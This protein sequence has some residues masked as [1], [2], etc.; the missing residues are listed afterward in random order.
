MSEQKTDIGKDKVFIYQIFYDQKSKEKLDPGF[1]PLDNSNNLR[2]DWY[3]FWPIR[4]FLNSHNLEPDAW[5]GFLSPRFSEKTGLNSVFLKN[6]LDN[7]AQNCEVLLFSYAWDQLSYFLNPFEQGEL[8][9]AGISE[10]TQ[11]FFDL[12]GVNININSFVTC[13]NTSVFSNYIIAKPSYWEKW[14]LLAEMF[15][16]V[17]EQGDIP[18]LTYNTSYVSPE[19]Q[20]PI[21]TFI[22][23]R[24]S[25]VILSSS[26][27]KTLS[28]DQSMTGEIFTMLFDDDIGTRR[29]LQTCDLLK[30]MYLKTNNKEYLNVFFNIRKDIKIKT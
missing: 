3:E 5:Y 19:N 21:K 6:I 23:E 12:S 25:S 4:N 2:P 18:E 11:K 29:R 28:I 9:H 7:H 13:C 20:T 16:N 14:L 22:Q 8:W 10:I 1:I 17:A 15:F 26:S 24:L 30:E 27:F